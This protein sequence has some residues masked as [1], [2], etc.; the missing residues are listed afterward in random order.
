MKMIK[1]GLIIGLS[2]LFVLSGCSNSESVKGEGGE[3]QEA[4]SVSSFNSIVVD[5]QYQIV[6]EVG[7]PQSLSISSNGNILPY[8]QTTVR[9]KVLH[10]DNKSAIELRPT[11]PQKINLKTPEFDAVTLAGE[12]T[13]TL[14]NLKSDKLDVALAGAHQLQLTGKAET[15]K[16]TVDGTSNIDAKA[17]TA[18]NIDITIN[19][20]GNV[21]VNPTKTLNVVINGS[22]KVI[23][24]GKSATVK[25]T[26]RGSGIVENGA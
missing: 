12:S 10:V 13:L 22:G 4:R 6:A 8:I 9:N 7:S 17:L 15:V 14:S 20:T 1:K 18:N 16:I 24:L 19:G 5:G 21:T 3:Q 26:I 23:Y 2:A 11:V 25:Q